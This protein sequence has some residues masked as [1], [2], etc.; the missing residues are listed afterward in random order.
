[1]EDILS[2]DETTD[3]AKGIMEGSFRFFE[4]EHVGSTT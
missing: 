1:V 3:Y 4:D 2:L